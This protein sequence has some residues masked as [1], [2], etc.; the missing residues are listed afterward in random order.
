MIYGRDLGCLYGQPHNMRFIHNGKTA[1]WESCVIC[2]RKFRWTKG[3]KGRIDN[4]E[5]LKAHV[6]QFAQRGGATKM[7]YNKLYKPKEMTIVI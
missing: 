2:G 5:Y 7:I 4:V 1:K 6:R 3:S